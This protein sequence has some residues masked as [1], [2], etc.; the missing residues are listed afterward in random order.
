MD[1]V[2]GAIGDHKG[3]S[4]AFA[5]GVDFEMHEFSGRAI[6]GSRDRTPAGDE[7][8]FV[9]GDEGSLGSD[10]GERGSA[11]RLF[12]IL[13]ASAVVHPI[14]SPGVSIQ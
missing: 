4:V 5:A 10:S 3:A 11:V 12:D 7:E 13:G 9:G 1:K 2:F 6:E 8:I 14:H